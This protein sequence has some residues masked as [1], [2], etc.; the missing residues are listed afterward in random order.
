MPAALAWINNVNDFVAACETILHE[1]KQHTKGIIV[2]VEKCTGMTHVPKLGSRKRNGMWGL[3]HEAS[4]SGTCLPPNHECT[5]P[6]RTSIMRWCRFWMGEI[7]TLIEKEGSMPFGVSEV[8]VPARYDGSVTASGRPSWSG[9]L[10]VDK[11]E[12]LGSGLEADRLMSD[13]RSG[14]QRITALIASSSAV[15]VNGFSRH[16]IVPLW[17]RRRQNC[18]SPWAVIKTIGICRPCCV[19]SRWSSIP[20]IPGIAMSRT[21]HLV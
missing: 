21:K 13:V 12:G 15:S 18:S 17:R 19:S 8:R 6:T 10:S 5:R 9:R 7:D 2:A 3:P 14:G 16:S 4:P 20:D 11:T 1:G